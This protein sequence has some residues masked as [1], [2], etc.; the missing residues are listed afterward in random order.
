MNN[1][2][3]NR[4]LLLSL[5]PIALISGWDVFAPFAIRLYPESNGLNSFASEL[6]PINAES[7]SIESEFYPYKIGIYSFETGFHP[8][9]IKIDADI[10]VAD[11]DKM[12]FDSAGIK[13][14]SNMAMY[15]SDEAWLYS[16][17]NFIFNQT[18]K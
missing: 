14:F 9:G 16:N 18:I 11:S 17:E 1:H 8:D 7:D 5:P 2:Y 6:N 15:V 13:M 10:T 4:I 3:Q 12:G